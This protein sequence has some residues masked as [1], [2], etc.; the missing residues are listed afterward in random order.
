MPKIKLSDTDR[1][2]L[3]RA[4]ELERNNGEPGRR[5]QLDDL[6]KT[7]GWFTA[8]ELATDRLQRRSLG[9]KM[10]QPKP[11]DIDPAEIE[12]ILSGGDDG[13]NGEYAAARLLKKMLAAGVSRFEPDPPWALAEARQKR[14]QPPAAEN[15]P[16]IGPK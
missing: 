5:Q 11:C 14:L 7:H 16:E 9:L 1:A 6:A 8:A 13:I 12:K 10:W 3:T 2:A 15:R 4:L